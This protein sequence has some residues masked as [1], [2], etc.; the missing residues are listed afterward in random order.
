MTLI[1]NSTAEALSSVHGHRKN[2]FWWGVESLI[3][4][5]KLTLTELGR[6]GTGPAFIKHKIKRSDRL[7]G[8]ERL[9]EES[10][11]YY[12]AL[13]QWLLK[14]VKRPIVLVDWTE[15]GVGF[16]ALV[17]SVPLEG[18]A[19][20]VYSEAHPLS[21]LGSRSVEGRFLESLRALMPEGCCPIVVTDA[22]FRTPWF[23]KLR[24]LEWDFVGRLRHRH[25]VQAGNGGWVWVK[26]FYKKATTTAK[27]LGWHLVT[28]SKPRWY[29]LVVIH[30]KVKRPRHALNKWGDR[31]QSR[32]TQ[33]SQKRAMEPWLLVTSLDKDAA[34]KI[35]KIY[36]LRMQ[37]E[38]TFRDIKSHRFGWSFDDARTSS[39]KRLDIFWL[40]ATYAHLIMT[41]LGMAA[42]A[43]GLSKTLQA[44]TSKTRVYS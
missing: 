16:H 44:N 31:C 11:T 23:D 43:K 27:S 3:R 6:S 15:T 24:E 5:G 34:K 13:A 14:G 32:R 38:E 26:N 21:S 22:G 33:V 19:L 20:V 8:N 12:S 10:F 40:I 42:H 7:F 18:R 36:S 41:V 39:T 9:H 1:Q 29:R 30:K 25:L 2:A 28:Q 17:A 35:V 4:G 37:T